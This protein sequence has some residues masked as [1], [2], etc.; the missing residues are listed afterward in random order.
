VIRLVGAGLL[1]L[2]PLLLPLGALR[3]LRLLSAEPV[4]WLATFPLLLAPV[5]VAAIAALAEALWWKKSPKGVQDLLGAVLLTALL[6]SLGTGAEALRAGAGE[7]SRVALS[8]GVAGFL[9]GLVLWFHRTP[10]KTFWLAALLGVAVLIGLGLLNQLS[11]VQEAWVR[12][13]VLGQEFIA[14]AALSAGALLLALGPATW[15][16][17][18][19]ATRPGAER[20]VSRALSLGQTIPTLVLFSAFMVLSTFTGLPGTGPLP[21]VAVLTLYAAFPVFQGAGAARKILDPGVREAALGLGYHP[22]ER[23][24]KIERPIVLPAYLTGVRTAA[25]QTVGNAVLAGLIGA[26]GLGSLL[27]L[28]LAQGSEDAVLLGALGTALLVLATSW[29]IDR[30]SGDRHD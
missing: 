7:L 2:S 20:W 9:V 29:L 16:G 17:W 12:R 19:L 4:W 14:H 5:L 13:K 22:W 28:G 3:P 6:W 1:V 21:A 26:G 8:W 23:F 27:F 11:L 18:S 24:W 25:V 10:G 15:A 30:L